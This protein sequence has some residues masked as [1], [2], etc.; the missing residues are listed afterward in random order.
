MFIFRECKYEGFLSR[1]CPGAAQDQT[2]CQLNP[3]PVWASWGSWSSCSVT[4]GH[5]QQ[6]R[7]RECE[8]KGTG[9]TGGNQEIRFCQQ[10]VCQ[11]N[12]FQLKLDFRSVLTLVNGSPGQRVLL[13][14]DVEQQNV[15]ANA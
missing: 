4:C 8:P 2:S 6:K 1:D 15:D 10:A 5:G 13:P 3:C 7:I 11:L 9:C 14:V 12:T